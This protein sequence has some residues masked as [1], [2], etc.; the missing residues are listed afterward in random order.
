[1]EKQEQKSHKQTTNITH[2]V[3]CLQNNQ[4]QTNPGWMFGNNTHFIESGNVQH[5][6]PKM[7]QGLS[8]HGNES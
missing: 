5:I 2:S 4:L 1:M 8:T 3:V 6:I 7:L